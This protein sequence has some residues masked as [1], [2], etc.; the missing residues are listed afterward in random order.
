MLVISVPGEQISLVKCVRGHTFLGETYITVTPYLEEFLTNR[1]EHLH[2]INQVDILHCGWSGQTSY[3]SS[4]FCDWSSQ[5]WYESSQFCDWSSQM[6]YKSSQFCDRLNCFVHH[7]VDI[8]TILRCADSNFVSTILKQAAH[9]N[10][11]HV[12]LLLLVLLHSKHSCYGISLSVTLRL[13]YA[14]CFT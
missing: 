1:I 2:D 7:R 13:W 3:K 9:H 5:M 8:I 11:F 14:N 6:W 4:Q 10:C 12:V